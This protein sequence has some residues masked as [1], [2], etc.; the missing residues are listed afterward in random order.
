[1]LGFEHDADA[2]GLELLLH[3]VGDLHREALLELKVT[4]EQ[5]DY[6]C[7]FREPD[8]PSPG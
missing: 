2:L 6:P 1:M 3:P 5:L 7:Q 4:G 8:D